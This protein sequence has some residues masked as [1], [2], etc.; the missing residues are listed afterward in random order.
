MAVLSVL[1]QKKG[2]GPLGVKVGHNWTISSLCLEVQMALGTKSLEDF[3][4]W[5]VHGVHAA[6]EKVIL[7]ITIVCMV[8]KCIHS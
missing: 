1:S 4:F 2:L 3:S 7:L 6:N 5:I 8:F